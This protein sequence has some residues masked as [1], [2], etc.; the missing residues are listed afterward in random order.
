M[1]LF[2]QVFSRVDWLV[3]EASRR[4]KDFAQILQLVDVDSHNI[5][6]SWCAQAHVSIH[7]CDFTNGYFQGQ[8]IDRILLYRIP[9][10][11]IPEKRIA[12]GESLASRVPVYGAANGSDAP[13]CERPHP[14]LDPTMLEMSS[15]MAEKHVQ[16]NTDCNGASVPD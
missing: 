9:A 11:G 16:V 1:F 4:Q 8:E 3:A 13:L 5:V 6:C 12:G 14:W 10:E 15:R 2:L 7:S